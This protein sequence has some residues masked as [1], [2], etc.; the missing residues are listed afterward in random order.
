V[1]VAGALTLLGCA[2]QP[3]VRVVGGERVEDRAIA[4][5]AYAAYLRGSLAESAGDWARARAEYR[6]VLSW[7]G[8]SVEARARLGRVECRASGRAAALEAAVSFAPGAELA[9]LE[10]A[11]CHLSQRRYGLA[12]HAAERAV[13]I[14]PDH[15]GASLVL[16]ESWARLGDRAEME[17]WLGAL[18]ARAFWT[19]GADG[20]GPSDQAPN[21][22]LR[23]ELARVRALLPRDAAD[24][25]AV[26]NRFAAVDRA[27]VDGDL[28]AA[29]SAASALMLPASELALRALALGLLTLAQEQADLVASAAPEDVNAWIVRLV[30]SRRAPAQ[31]SEALVVP[32]FPHEPEAPS[33][34]GRALLAEFLWGALGFDAA[35]A[36]LNAVQLDAAQ[37]AAAERAA[38]EWDPLLARVYARLKAQ[39]E[40]QGVRASSGL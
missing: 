39:L 28:E 35:N 12:R 21:R 14:A 36:W 3:V 30:V 9:W 2:R 8:A 4:S 15:E 22:A 13:M 34:L 11:R 40:A 6:R 24:R 37:L 10:L 32:A 20:Q 23:E 27:L 7:D 31:P 25:A 38:R 5:E 18:E 19:R 29:R 1:C 17:R 26:P 16:A 33:P